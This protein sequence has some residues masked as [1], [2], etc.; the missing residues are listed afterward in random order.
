MAY[1][2]ERR[3]AKVPSIDT[4]RCPCRSLAW[5]FMHDFFLPV[6]ASGTLLKLKVKFSY[7]SADFRLLSLEVCRRFRVRVA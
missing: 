6:E 7:S 5:F 4:V 3:W 1:I 2:V